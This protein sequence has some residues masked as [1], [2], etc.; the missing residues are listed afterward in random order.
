MLTSVGVVALREAGPFIDPENAFDKQL[1]GRFSRTLDCLRVATT[2]VGEDEHLVHFMTDRY[3]DQYFRP[4]ESIS[5]ERTV[6]FEFSRQTRRL[7]L[8]NPLA[9]LFQQCGAEIVLR[10]ELLMYRMSVA[11]DATMSTCR[12]EVYANDTV[13]FNNWPWLSSTC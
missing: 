11:D 7:L 12:L 3:L 4:E 13:R 8:S 1:S 2:I 6:R 5:T 9:K 10:P